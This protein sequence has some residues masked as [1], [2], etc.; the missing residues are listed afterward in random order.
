MTFLSIGYIWINQREPF[1]KTSRSHW[2]HLATLVR[3]I[4]SP[5]KIVQHTWMNVNSKLVCSALIQLF[6]AQPASQFQEMPGNNSPLSPGRRQS[7]AGAGYRTGV[8]CCWSNVGMWRCSL[9]S[10]VTWDSFKSST[11]SVPGCLSLGLDRQKWIAGR[12]LI[13]AT[14]NDVPN[15]ESQKA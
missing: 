8:V 4:S 7:N 3:D 10:L 5:W 14:D 12:V 13:M 15:N 2:A 6:F 9:P 1:Y 11:A